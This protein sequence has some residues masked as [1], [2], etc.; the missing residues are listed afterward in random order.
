VF[1]LAEDRGETESGQRL[2]QLDIR[3]AAAEEN[4]AT[5]ALVGPRVY[6]QQ[7]LGIVHGGII[8]CAFD[9]RSRQTSCLNHSF[10]RLSSDQQATRE[11][12]RILSRLLGFCRRTRLNMF[13]PVRDDRKLIATS[14]EQDEA[15]SSLSG[16][17]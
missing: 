3:K 10:E 13:T 8:R 14:A 6:V 2:A 16:N 4:Q 12:T 17:E 9:R 11:A 1:E 7:S 15:F 5:Q